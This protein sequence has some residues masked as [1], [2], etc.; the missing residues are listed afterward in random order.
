VT[1]SQDKIYKITEETDWL[2]E[3]TEQRLKE[4]QEEIKRLKKRAKRQKWWNVWFALKR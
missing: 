4:Q 3:N 1:E 2:M